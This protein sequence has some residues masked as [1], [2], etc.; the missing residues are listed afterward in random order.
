MT[1]I[2]TDNQFEIFAVAPPGLEPL[3][4][5]EFRA[6][7]YKDARYGPGGVTLMGD[8]SDVWRLNLEL[9][10]ASKVLARMGSFRAMDLAR[11]DH[12]ATQFP[13]SDFLLPNTD[14]RVEVT[15]KRSKIYHAGAAVQRIE[16][17]LRKVGVTVSQQ[18]NVTLKIRIEQNIVSVSVDT[19]GEG[20]HKRG[21]KEAVGKAPMRETMAALLLRQAGYDG[22][23]AVLD[24][25]CG[26]GTF[27]IEA[28]EI[29]QGLQPG[30]SRDFAFEKLAGFNAKTFKDMRRPVSTLDGPPLFFGSDRDSGVISMA[31][32]NAERAEVDALCQFKCHDVQELECPDV[33]PG[34]VI[35]NPPYGGRIGNKKHLY[36]VYGKL[37]VTLSEK[38]SGWRVGIITSEPGLAK[39]TG[40]PLTQGPSVPHGGLKVCLHQTPPLA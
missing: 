13:W 21:H 9:R 40:L 22:A 26:S 38:F 39:A 19:S 1:D 4:L 11:L 7:G 30:R 24:P 3:L 12:R 32:A 17:A 8:W 27:L 14:V 34:L 10:G 35:V 6:L 31:Q 33:P 15:C 29:A 36:A 16:R 37:G 23:D 18:G 20:L 28:A 2:L 5:P 25:M